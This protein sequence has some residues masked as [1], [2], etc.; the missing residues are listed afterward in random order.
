LRTWRSSCCWLDLLA[1]GTGDG[2]RSS[3][4]LRGFRRRRCAREI[5]RQR[6]IAK[7]A[8]AH[9]GTKI[10]VKRESKK[11]CSLMFIGHTWGSVELLGVL[12]WSSET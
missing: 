1:G 8:R 7:K 6:Q 12:I 5:G 3:A 11:I 4:R 10:D 9:E 2:Q